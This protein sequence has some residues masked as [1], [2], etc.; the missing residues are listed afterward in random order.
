MNPSFFGFGR[1][2]RFFGNKFVKVLKDHPKVSLENF[3]LRL[4]SSSDEIETGFWRAVILMHY[5]RYA[6]QNGFEFCFAGI[7][8]F[9]S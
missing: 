1:P 9:R 2:L 5:R 7:Q 6:L 3:V 8:A 4:Q